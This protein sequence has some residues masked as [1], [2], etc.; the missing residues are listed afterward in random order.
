[1]PPDEVRL[2]HMLDAARKAMSFAQGR[3]RQDLQ[4]DEQFQ[5]ATVRAIEIVGE[6]AY[7]LTEPTKQTIPDIPWQDIIGSR[8][9]LVHGY[10]DINLDYVWA[11]LQDDLPV[12]IKALERALENMGD[13]GG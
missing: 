8:H 2:R 7:K 12:L 10:F 13:Q 6:A 5:F 9:H 11:T 1:M 3:T 4:S